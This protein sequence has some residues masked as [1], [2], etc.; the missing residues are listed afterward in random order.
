MSDSDDEFSDGIV[1]DDQML[2]VLDEEESRFQ[3]ATQLNTDDRGPPVKRRKLDTGHALNRGVF[4]SST[5][6]DIEDLPDI[7]VS[8]DGTY[9]VEPQRS[10][11]VALN[12]ELD[13]STKLLTCVSKPTVVPSNNRLGYTA[14]AGRNPTTHARRQPSQFRRP[15]S[16]NPTRVPSARVE[17]GTIPHC[18]SD[19]LPHATTPL[20]APLFDAQLTDMRKLMNEV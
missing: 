17:I 9:V 2:A 15:S 5:S 11:S 20:P 4:D 7:T 16:T 8:S 1:L 13:G 19:S 3:R 14:P 18:Q 10:T 12:A 6:E